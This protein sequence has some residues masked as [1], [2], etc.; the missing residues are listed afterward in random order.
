[1]NMKKS[2]HVDEKKSEEGVWF[3]YEDAEFLIGRS[4]SQ[5]YRKEIERLSRRYRRQIDLGTLS[6]ETNDEIVTRAMANAILNDWRGHV[7]I[8][9]DGEDLPYSRENAFLLLKEFPDFRDLVASWA[10]DIE[11]FQAE[12]KDDE[13][14]NSDSS[15]SGS[16]NTTRMSK[17]SGAMSTSST[18][19]GT[20]A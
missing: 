2:F 6:R 10:Q 11:A 20:T 19:P 13:E 1:M 3:P 17:V 5:K 14:K 15:S 8:D 16:S 4:R 7:A 18:S 12:E 9:D